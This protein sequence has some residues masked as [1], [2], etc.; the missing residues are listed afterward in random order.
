MWQGSTEFRECDHPGL[1][2]VPRS[3]FTVDGMSIDLITEDDWVPEACTLPTAERPLRRAEFDS[4][5][6]NDVVGLVHESAQRVRLEL[7]ADPEVAARAADLSVKETGCCSFFAF[8][9]SIADGHVTLTI[10]APEPHASVIAALAA[11]AE[12]RIGDSA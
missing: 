9:L 5:F 6:A 7:R 10:S 1:H 11:R 4:L 12:S 3:G 8:D 2:S